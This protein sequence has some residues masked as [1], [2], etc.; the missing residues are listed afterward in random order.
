MWQT[1]TW[2]RLWTDIV[3]WWFCRGEWDTE[4][5]QPL[6]RGQD[7]CSTSVLRNS[8]QAA[9][10][11]LSAMWMSF[12]LVSM[13]TFLTIRRMSAA[14]FVSQR[15]PCLL[16][17]CLPGS[18]RC[19]GTMLSI[20]MQLCSDSVNEWQVKSHSPLSRTH[21][22]VNITAITVNA[23]IIVHVSYRWRAAKGWHI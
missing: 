22:K 12:F 14:L 6:V 9:W 5:L 3:L 18:L 23:I 11:W 21:K 15:Q 20:C 13:R 7:S 4:S 2:A 10:L 16:A 1:E 17:Q 8:A 19:T